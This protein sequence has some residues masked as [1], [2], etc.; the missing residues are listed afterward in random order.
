MLCVK[1]F[2]KNVDNKKNYRV[3]LHTLYQEITFT[4]PYFC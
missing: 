3:T 2:F 4:D 1:F